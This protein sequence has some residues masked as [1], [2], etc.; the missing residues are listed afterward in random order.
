M[1][2]VLGC[3]KRAQTEFNMIEDGDVVGVG[4]SGGKDSMVLLRALSLFRRFAPVSFDLKA[5]TVDMG[6]E[7][8]EIEKISEF[9]RREDVDHIVVPTDLGR[10]IFEERQEDNP[11]GL[12][13]R[14]RR[15]ILN[16]VCTENGITRLALGHHGDDLAETFLMSLLYESRLSAF[17]AVTEFERAE[18]K[19]I[20]PLIFATEADVE[21]AAASE[22]IVPV[23]NPCPASGKT[24]R[25]DMKK[26]VDEMEALSGMPR[27][28]IINALCR[29]TLV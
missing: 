26:L 29:S 14:M 27:E 11:C 21:R 24:R 15:G 6:F 7:G 9:C 3:I 12:C 13:S 8:F 23:T 4:L 25:E 16:R 5:V 20:R 10:L 1:R 28:H 17:K 18:A 2:K 19:Q 22:G